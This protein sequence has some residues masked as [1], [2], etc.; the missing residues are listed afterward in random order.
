MIEL[1]LVALAVGLDNLG[2]AIALGTGGV[3]RAQRVRV[4]LIF[5][6]FEAGMPVLG[7]LTG[8]A[9]AGDLGRSGPAV[10]GTL[11]GAMGVYSLISALLKRPEH[12][13]VARPKVGQILLLG[14]VLSIDNLVIGF[15][16]G[17]RH[18]NLVVAV[19]VIGAVST[20]LSLVG[21]EVGRR[22]GARFGEASEVLGG[23]VL[24][25]VGIAVGTQLL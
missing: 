7:I 2:A 15:A 19:V 11:L 1:L 25:V 13:S 4:G 14:V 22:I 21:L 23:L 16:L 10:A 5:G 8:R 24:I 9:V 17:S 12:R 6:F 20:G 18:T 3:D